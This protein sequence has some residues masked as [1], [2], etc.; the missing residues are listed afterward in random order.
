VLNN[1]RNNYVTQIWNLKKGPTGGASSR[2]LRDNFRFSRAR[3]FDSF[4]DGEQVG[5]QPKTKD[6]AKLL[7][8][9]LHEMNSVIAARQLVEQMSG[10][11]ASDGRPLVAPRGVGVPVD[12][13]TGKATLV[14]PRAVKGDTGDYKTLDSQPAMTGWRWVSKDSDGK[15]VFMKSDLALHP[16]AYGKLKNVLSK[17]KARRALRFL[18]R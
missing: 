13:A 8:V 4:F 15:P 6:I 3:T 16:E 9:Y 5:F 11:V 7:P 12:D 18:K 17:A 1:F 14:M 2:T 10:G